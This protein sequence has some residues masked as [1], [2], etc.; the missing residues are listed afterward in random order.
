MRSIKTDSVEP[1]RRQRQNQ[2]QL[3][4]SSLIKGRSFVFPTGNSTLQPRCQ[5]S[6]LDRAS[7]PF[8]KA[9]QLDWP[10]FLPLLLGWRSSVTAYCFK[11]SSISPPCVCFSHPYSTTNSANVQDFSWNRLSRAKKENPHGQA[12]K[13]V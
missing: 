8:F 10:P 11:M 7:S 13:A 4:G 12:G 3:Q 9:A 2:F 6:L 1:T 5:H